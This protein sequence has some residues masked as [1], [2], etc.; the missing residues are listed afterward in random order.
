MNILPTIDVQ[1]SKV[2]L[3]FSPAGIPE[4]VRS[5][6]RKVLPDLTKTV[7]QAVD[8][9]LSTELKSRKSLETKKELVENPT[10]IYGRV[11][12]TSSKNPLLPQ[13]LETGTRPHDIVARNAKVL[14][15]YWARIGGMAFFPKV[16]HPGFRGLHY[17]QNTF[18]EYGDMIADRIGDAVGHGLQE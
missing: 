2:M 13:W 6:L 12:V 16:H 9:R 14:A 5:N 8:A 18:L 11:R 17:M 1:M 4:A 10:S 15:F 7:G 3:R